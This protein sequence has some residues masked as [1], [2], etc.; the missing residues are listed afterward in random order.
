MDCLLLH[1]AQIIN[2]RGEEEENLP[3]FTSVPPP[4]LSLPRA[5]AIFH[6][7]LKTNAENL[8][9]DRSVQIFAQPSDLQ[10]SGTLHTFPAINQ[11]ASQL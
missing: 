9:I 7:D 2:A 4:H 10:S 8:Q 1:N 6:T 11:V 3:Q 5:P